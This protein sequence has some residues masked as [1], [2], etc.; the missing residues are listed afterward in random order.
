M[1]RPLPYHSYYI[2]ICYFVLLWCCC[3]CWMLPSSVH[4]TTTIS[5]STPED[6]PFAAAAAASGLNRDRFFEDI[7]S[8]IGSLSEGDTGDGYQVLDPPKS[9]T[10]PTA[11]NQWIPKSSLRKGP[12]KDNLHVGFAEELPSSSYL[13]P[14]DPGMKPQPQQQQ[15]RSRRRPSIRRLSRAATPQ[16]L[17]SSSEDLLTLGLSRYACMRERV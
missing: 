5:L 14:Q 9:S 15:Q 8:S 17:D 2:I 16:S 10:A 13:P 1:Q 11:T 12:S 3:F 4:A 6:S 7:T